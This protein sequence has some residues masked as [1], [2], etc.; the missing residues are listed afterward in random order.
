MKKTIFFILSF[1]ITSSSYAIDSASLSNGGKLDANI[2]SAIKYTVPVGT[3]IT[4]PAYS[5]PDGWSTDINDTEWLE[6]NGGI[7]PAVYTDL[8]NVLQSSNPHYTGRLPNYQGMFLRGYGNQTI[9]QNN[10]S[11]I[12]VTGTTHRADNLGTTQGDALRNI[13]GR[14]AFQ[15]NSGIVRGGDTIGG[16]FTRGRARSTSALNL[17]GYLSFDLNI[18]TSLAVPTDNEI[19]PA[20][21]AVRYFIKTR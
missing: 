21:V 5:Y 13:T 8:I 12:G 19:R 10:G 18:D 7:I 3:V 11:L 15:E 20:N 2:E 6:C 17:D 9:Y 14:A 1:F 4:W 16:V